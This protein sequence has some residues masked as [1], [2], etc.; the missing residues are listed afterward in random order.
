L[1]RRKW[2]HRWS[3]IGLKR[4]VLFYTRYDRTARNSFLGPGI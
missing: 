1:A 3:C 2:I 4:T